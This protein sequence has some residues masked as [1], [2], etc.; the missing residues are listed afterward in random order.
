M[1]SGVVV[2]LC[3]RADSLCVIFDAA[4]TDPTMIWDL[5]VNSSATSQ[6]ISLRGNGT[7]T[8]SQYSPKVF[9]LSAGTH[10]LIVRGRE[11]NT[12]LGTITISPKS[13]T[14]TPPSIALTSPA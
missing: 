4:P 12:Q 8:S 3:G 13:T 10:Q 2:S 6:Y 14:P 7:S 9:T 11:P 5:P 1:G